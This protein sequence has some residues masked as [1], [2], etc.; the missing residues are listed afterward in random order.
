MTTSLLNTFHNNENQS[1]K[2]FPHNF[3]SATPVISLTN[4]FLVFVL[5]LKDFGFTGKLNKLRAYVLFSTWSLTHR[6]VGVP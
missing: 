3:L 6:G 2:D 4:F 5:K 1:P